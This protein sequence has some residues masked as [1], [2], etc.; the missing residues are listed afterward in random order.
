MAQG[1]LG[2]ICL[3]CF[4]KIYFTTPSPT[5]HLKK[6]KKFQ[7]L[8]FLFVTIFFKRKLSYLIIRSGKF[9]NLVTSFF[10]EIFKTHFLNVVNF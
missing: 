10:Y 6:I 4:N 9:G 2:R 7:K 1:L 8:I 5:P 3:K